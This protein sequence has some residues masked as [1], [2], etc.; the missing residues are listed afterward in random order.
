MFL[1]RLQQEH[2]NRIKCVFTEYV[3]YR[4]TIGYSGDTL[5]FY[6]PNINFMNM[7]NLLKDNLHCNRNS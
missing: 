3:G 6:S 4:F 5:L 1:Y 7:W 2:P